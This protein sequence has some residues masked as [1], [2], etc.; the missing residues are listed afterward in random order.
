M[1]NFKNVETKESKGFT[2]QY[3]GYGIHLLKINRAE[4][5]RSS[6]GDKI[7]IKFNVE[8][9]EIKDFEGADLGD[10]VKAKGLV[11]WVNLGSYFDPNDSFRVN[12]LL[13]NL[14][15]IA[16]KANVAD[17]LEAI[18]ASTIEDLIEKFIRIVQGKFLWFLI[19]GDEYE[20]NGKRGYALSFKE[21]K[22]G[23]EEGKKLFQIVVK[24]EKFKETIEEKD[25]RIVKV[26]G[27]NTIGSSI[28]KK[29]TLEFN[30][31]YDLKPLEP[32]DK[33]AEEDELS[34]AKDDLPF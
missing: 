25:G 14:K 24:E 26:F 31:T 18:E 19:K 30:P 4:I 21:F 3:I 6:K 22:V 29:D 12:A 33:E 11:G 23:E 2:Q 7:Q 5:K 27:T 15:A 34:K 10:G 17:K 13:A 9:P 28:G 1:L 20:S 16:E 8:G 32:S